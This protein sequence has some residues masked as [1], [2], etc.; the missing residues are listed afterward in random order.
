MKE[1]ILV[2]DI[3]GEI[4]HFCYKI[5][6]NYGLGIIIFT[7]LSKI[8]LI[9][10][11]IW[12]Q[13][14]SIKIVKLQPEINKIKI[15]YFKDNDRIAE[16]EGE[17]Y[18][19]EKYNPFLSLI[20]LFFQIAILLGLISVI[21]KPLT[22]ITK[23]DK[24]LIEDMNKITLKNNPSINKDSSSIEVYTLDDIK[25]NKN[26]D[27]YKELNNK[28]KDI[29][30]EIYIIQKVNIKLL[31]FD[32]TKT[33]SKDKGIYLLV[34]LIAGL[35]ALLLSLAQNKMNILQSVQGIKNKLGTMSFTVGLSLYLGFFVSASVALYWIV[36][37]LLTIV[38]QYILNLIINP[39]KYVDFEELEKTTKELK[40]LEQIDKSGKT[41][42]KEEKIKEKQDYKRFFGIVNKHLVFYSES[43]GFYKYYKSMIEYILKNT[44][45]TIH[46]ITSDF[47]DN[48][49]NM[50]KEN[51]SRIKAYFISERKLITLMMKMDA[52]VVVMTMP[53]LENFHIKRSYVRKD[54]EYIYVPHGMNSLNMCQRTSSMDHY[55]TVFACGK[56][57]REE[58]EKGNIVYNLPNR[59]IFNWGYSLLD[60]MIEEYNSKNKKESNKKNVLIAP[61]WQKD[62]IVDLCLDEVLEKLKGHDYKIIVRPHP[63]HVKHAKERFEKLKEIYKDDS[64]IDIQT[65]F[66]SNS[67]VFDADL[68]IT[69]WSGI[70]F[71]YAFTTLKPVLFIDTPMKVMNPEYKKIDVEPFNI[72]VREKIGKV[73]KLDNLNEIDNTVEYLLKNKDKYKKDIDKVL[74][75]YFYNIGTSGEEGAKYIIECVQ[76]KIKE[77]KESEK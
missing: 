34:P 36:S 61:S 24:N 18:K 4:M 75:E 62:N 69:D 7:F 14:N 43:N 50:E 40:E 10:M 19:K 17:L 66:S 23:T 68:V 21:N 2:I 55:D 26:I 42:S 47:N 54:I 28:Y 58:F 73:I 13:K 9:P 11:M 6:N 12:V 46:Y 56:H 16:E 76:K 53:D 33:A 3:L 48:I 72:W 77:K 30:K 32:L 25:N 8:I 52:D 35:S 60:D 31:C 49:F 5:F 38:Q 71:E 41:L 1:V 27:S 51:P 15:K 70:A 44:K 22:Y 67:T 64:S 37:N 57:Q 63:Q 65:D 20:P 74:H 45:I 39:K 59:K 29:N